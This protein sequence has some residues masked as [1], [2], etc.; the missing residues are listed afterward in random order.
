[1]YISKQET[2][3]CNTNRCFIS[4][5]LLYWVNHHE[6][7][8][9]A[10]RKVSSIEM[11]GDNSQVPGHS[12]VPQPGTPL[13]V[14][15][16]LWAP[17]CVSVPLWPPPCVALVPESLLPS[18]ARVCVCVRPRNDGGSILVCGALCLGATHALCLPRTKMI[19]N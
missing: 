19:R 4:F 6:G 5:P 11:T 7:M 3:V 9:A 13:A 12:D 1:M 10:G 17:P 15:V 18:V 16:P 2:D 14:S 8:I